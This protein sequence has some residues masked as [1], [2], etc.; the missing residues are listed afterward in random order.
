M[1]QSDIPRSTTHLHKTQ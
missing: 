1:R